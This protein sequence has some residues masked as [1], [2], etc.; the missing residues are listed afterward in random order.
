MY[1]FVAM[2]P[3]A[4]DEVDQ[5]GK[6]A[7]IV[8]QFIRT[9]VGLCIGE[10]KCGRDQDDIGFVI[11]YDVSVLRTGPRTICLTYFNQALDKLTPNVVRVRGEQGRVL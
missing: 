1:S 4:Q 3:G 5:S 6:G 2:L 9:V 10:Q 7:L 8:Q 11:L